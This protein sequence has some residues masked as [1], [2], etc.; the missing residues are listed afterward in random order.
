MLRARHICF[1]TAANP[2]IYTGDLGLESKYDTLKKIPE[3]YR[4]KAC[5]IPSGVPIQEVRQQL[6]SVGIT[7]PL[8]AKPDLGFRGLLVRKVDDEAALQAY[9]TQFPIDFVLQEFLDFPEE[10]GVLY[11]RLPGAEMGRVSSLTTK[12]FLSVTGDGNASVEALILQKDRA[13]LQL[14]RIRTQQPELLQQV[15][16]AG[17]EIPLGIV[18]N[19]AKGTRFIN[20]TARADEAITQ[21]IDAIARQIDGFYYGRFDLKCAS[22]DSLRTGEG[23]RIIEVNGVCSE[24][25]HI[26]DPQRGTYFSA[27]RDIAHHW[28]LIYRIAR[29]NHRNGAPYMEVRKLARA[30]LDLFAYQRRIAEIEKQSAVGSRQCAVHQ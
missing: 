7:F 5:L 15:P 29:A 18:G 20:S 9:L 12:E 14:E 19:H 24:P 27:L 26:Y 23:I 10:I 8:I 2:G 28:S 4:P 3:R 13:H 22:F 30:F 1:F 11:Y 21:T 25:T 16:V 6:A 17:E